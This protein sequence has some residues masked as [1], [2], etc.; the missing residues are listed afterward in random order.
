MNTL[1]L[2]INPDGTGSCIYSELIDLQ[3]IGSLEIQRASFIEFNN[4]TQRWEVKGND[5]IIL[6]D[7]LSRSDCLGWEQIHFD[8]P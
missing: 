4:S 7:S 5:G 3:T 2:T 6:F 1:A 8:A